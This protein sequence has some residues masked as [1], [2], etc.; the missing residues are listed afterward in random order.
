MPLTRHAEPKPRHSE[1]NP[2]HS[3]PEAKNLAHPEA[4][5]NDARDSSFL[6]MTDVWRSGWGEGEGDSQ[7]DRGDEGS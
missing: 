4:D 1:P 3:E 7:V 5:F 6:R 2:C